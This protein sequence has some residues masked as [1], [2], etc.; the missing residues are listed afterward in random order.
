MDLG[1]E[2]DPVVE[3]TKRMSGSNIKSGCRE[4]Q[5][6]SEREGYYRTCQRIFIDT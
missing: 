1:G 3:I 5:Q 4:S 6:G 2:P